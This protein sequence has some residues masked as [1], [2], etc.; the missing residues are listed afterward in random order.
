MN[1]F[2]LRDTNGRTEVFDPLRR[3]YVA[4]TPEEKVRQIAAHRL[5]TVNGYPAGRVAIEY[6]LR[7]NKLERRCDI[8]IFSS[9]S[10]PWMIV[11]CKAASVKLNQTV[12]DQAV[13]YSLLLPVRYVLITNGEEQYCA[14]ID[15]VSN[16]FSFLN[17]LPDYE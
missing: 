16:S 11:E 2:N 10:T 5:I 4:L 6:T 17:K 12:L 9:D 13:A 7:S 8:L 1:W 15:R 14:K 3:K